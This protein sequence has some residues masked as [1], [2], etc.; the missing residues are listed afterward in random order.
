MIVELVPKVGGREDEHDASEDDAP[1]LNVPRFEDH[2]WSPDESDGQGK[3]ASRA[4]IH[5]GGPLYRH[6]KRPRRP[7]QAMADEWNSSHGSSV[8][9]HPTYPTH[10]SPRPGAVSS[11]AGREEA[12][13][14][15]LQAAELRSA[16][17]PRRHRAPC[18]RPPSAQSRSRRHSK[19]PSPRQPLQTRTFRASPRAP[20]QH[21]PHRTRARR[22]R[23]IGPVSTGPGL[24]AA[25][26][27][28]RQ[29]GWPASVGCGRA[30][31]PGDTGSSVTSVFI[32]QS[33]TT[34]A[35]SGGITA[36]SAPR[37]RVSDCTPGSHKAIGGDSRGCMPLPHGNVR[38]AMLRTAHARYRRTATCGRRCCALH[39]SAIAAAPAPAR[40]NQGSRERISGGRSARS[41]QALGSEQL[42]RPRNGEAA[43]AAGGRAA[44]A[45]GGEVRRSALALRPRPISPGAPALTWRARPLS[46]GA[47]ALTWHARPLSP[48][49]PALTWRPRPLSPGGRVRSHPARPLSLGGRARSHPGGLLDGFLRAA[50]RRLAGHAISLRL[51]LRAMPDHVVSLASFNKIL[52]TGTYLCIYL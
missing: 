38:A 31:R 23:P 22:R 36:A 27:A 8:P 18:A 9:T 45:R 42:C 14:L 50:P 12:G 46:P 39:T 24:R 26:P 25:V 30:L 29:S 32:V 7:C 20:V 33:E 3:V 40:P 41:A 2:L 4:S 28:V 34:V 1:E 37:D 17:A 15:G 48:R 10:P 47:P 21:Q 16:A 11:C 5:T 19:A 51:E 6:S 44:G 49:A 52:V 13:L 43:W 35:A